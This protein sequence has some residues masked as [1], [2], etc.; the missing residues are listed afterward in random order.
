VISTF[1][2][3]ED[4]R[5]PQKSKQSEDRFIPQRN[6]PASNDLFMMSNKEASPSDISNFSELEKDKLLYSNLLDQKMLN[7]DKYTLNL[8]A[9]GL[10]STEKPVKNR[11]AKL[12]QF[13]HKKEMTSQMLPGSF[14]IDEEPLF[15]SD[16]VRSIK[17]SRRIPKAPTKILDAPGVLDDFYQDILDWSSKDVIAISLENSIYFFKNKLKENSVVKVTELMDNVFSTVKFSP[18]GSLLAAGEE[19]GHTYIYDV[20]KETQLFQV[21]SHTD[22]VCSMSWMNENVLST[23]SRDTVIKNFDLR[24]KGHISSLHKHAQEVCGLRWS[25]DENFLASGG[26]ENFINIWDIRKYRN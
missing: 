15:E 24:T 17:Y 20:A 22:R 8:N 7:F 21:K 6:T 16:L 1:D 23:G 11:R 25:P 12:L 9:K 26:N 4:I 13:S 5:T 14:V 2:A 19:N 18:S 3:F 10:R